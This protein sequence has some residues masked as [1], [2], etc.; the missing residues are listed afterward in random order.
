MQS[1][2]SVIHADEQSDD[3]VFQLHSEEP[4]NFYET[5]DTA[6]KKRKKQEKVIMTSEKLEIQVNDE[7]LVGSRVL[8]E[9][10]D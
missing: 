7:D 3:Q 9:I 4:F 8:K 10:D 5:L 1:P 6:E 2:D